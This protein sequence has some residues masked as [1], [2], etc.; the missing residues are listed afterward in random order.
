MIVGGDAHVVPGEV[1]GEGV[2]RLP[3]DAVVAV[4]VHDAHDEVRELPLDGHGEVPVQGGVVHP[5]GMGLDLPDQGHQIPA[6]GGEEPVAGVPGQAPLKL[7]QLG[8]VGVLLRLT[9]ARQAAAAVEDPLEIRLKQGIVAALLGLVPHGVGLGHQLLIGHKF[10]LGNAVGLFV[11]PP[12]LRYLPG[13]DGVQPVPGLH[14]G[15]E[16]LHR[17]RG[18]GQNVAHAGQLPQGVGPDVRRALGGNGGSVVIQH[19]GGVVIGKGLLFIGGQPFQCLRYGHFASPP[20]S[21]SENIVPHTTP[22]VNR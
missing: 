9:I 4:D 19:A 12:K 17:L 20:V 13:G 8:V 6:Q 1:D 21:D 10:L 15:L 16:H 7:V 11:V 18:G 5:V 2:L 14:Q 3:H 22:D